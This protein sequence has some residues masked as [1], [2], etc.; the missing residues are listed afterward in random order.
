MMQSSPSAWELVDIPYPAAFFSHLVGP[1]DSSN[2]S[3]N[4]SLPHPGIRKIGRL[5]LSISTELL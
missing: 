3:K 4:L 5:S 1:G 2:A